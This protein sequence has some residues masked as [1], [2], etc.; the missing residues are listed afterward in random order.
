MILRQKGLRMLF[1]LNPEQV[2]ITDYLGNSAEI[3]GDIL[4]NRG[5]HREDS[6]VIL[7]GY[8]FMIE[9]ETARM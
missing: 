6:K 2:D 7:D 8:G 3:N 1:S 4:I 5:M 9:T